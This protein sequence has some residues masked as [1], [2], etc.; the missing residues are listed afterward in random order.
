MVLKKPVRL[1]AEQ[2]VALGMELVW[3]VSQPGIIEVQVLHVPF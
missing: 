1:H 2:V 3:Q